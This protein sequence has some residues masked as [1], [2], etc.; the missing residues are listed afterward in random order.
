MSYLFDGW[1]LSIKG[2][3]VV[4]MQSTQRVQ[5]VLYRVQHVSLGKTR[6]TVF[7]SV[8]VSCNRQ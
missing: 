1:C 5:S 4:H 3:G 2:R 7:M 8:G 6:G